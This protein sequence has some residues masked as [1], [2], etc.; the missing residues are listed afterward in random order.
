MKKVLFLSGLLLAIFTSCQKDINEVLSGPHLETD[1]TALTLPAVS[2]ATDSFRIKASVEW[3]ITVLPATAD[4]FTT[5]ITTGNGDSKIV[6]TVTKNNTSDTIQKATI[7]ISAVNNT[8]VKPVTISVSQNKP[9]KKSRNAYGGTDDDKFFYAVATADGGIIAVGES[10]STDGDVSGNK[11]QEDA[12]IIKIDA[13]GEKVWQKTLGGTGR[14]AAT[15]ITPTSDGN[16]LIAAAGSSDGDFAG[17][18]GTMLVKIDGNGNILS[19]KDMPLSIAG[20]V[21][22]TGGGY[23]MGG[24]VNNDY[25]LAKTDANFNVLWV[26]TYGGTGQDWAVSIVEASD[27]N[28]YV[29]AGYSDSNDGNITGNKGYGDYWVIKVDQSGSLVW[30]KSYG[31]SWYE[32]ATSMART[33]DGGYVIAGATESSDGDVVNKYANNGYTND[34]DDGWV[35]KIDANGN[36]VWTKTLGGTWGDVFSCITPAQSGGFLLSGYTRSNDGNIT[37]LDGVSDVW[38]VKLGENGNLLWSKTP[39]GSDEEYGYYILESSVGNYVALGNTFSN[40][41]DV[42]GLHG[43]GDGWIYKF[44]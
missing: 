32:Y 28:G 3:Q 4:W 40:D 1:S 39:G 12:W 35:I 18:S 24:A 31:G 16:Y 44:K 21:P 42:V 2:A 14:D 11:G 30:Q 20:I 34:A 6:V 26:K 41:G 29:L 25:A 5:N 7:I 8:S 27:N 22:V 36:K 38:A 37:D 15:Y 9:E 43:Y 17:I 13:N 19:K 33:Q 10:T 23:V